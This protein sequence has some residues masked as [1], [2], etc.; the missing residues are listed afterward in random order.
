MNYISRSK[1]RIITEFDQFR[2]IKFTSVAKPECICGECAALEPF[3]IKRNISVIYS[4]GTKNLASI[5]MRIPQSAKHLLFLNPSIKIMGVCL[6][7]SEIYQIKNQYVILTKFAAA[8]IT[9][10]DLVIL[11][12]NGNII[13][14]DPIDGEIDLK[15]FKTEHILIA[16]SYRQFEYFK[17]ESNSRV[18]LVYH[19]S[20]FRLKE[21]R[22]QNKYFSLAYFGSLSRI[23]KELTSIEFL[24][25]I[26]TPLSFEPKLKN[27]RFS[28]YLENHSAHLTVGSVVPKMVFKP[29][30]KGLV[31]TNIGAVTLISRDDTEALLL[32]GSSYP[33]VAATT[34]KKS[35]LEVANYMMD[36]FLDIE[37]KFAHSLHKKLLPLCCEQKIAFNWG[38]LFLHY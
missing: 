20:D 34:K 8:N 15:K 32:L 26:K 5:Q 12:R 4:K 37:W 30:T 21:V 29:F 3:S 16:S 31:A 11:N 36:T 35:I 14:V 6:Q 27:P 7:S 22:A 1:N 24:S 25:I 23:P 28:N 9:N 10:Y 2:S 38:R 19:A 18:E 13:F 17:N 33:Y